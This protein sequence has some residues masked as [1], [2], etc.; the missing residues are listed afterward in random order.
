[1]KFKLDINLDDE[2][3]ASEFVAKYQ[4]FNTRREV[5][6]AMGLKGKGAHKLAGELHS[7]AFYKV[8]AIKYRKA[9]SIADALR[10]EAICDRI[11]SEGIQ[12]HCEC[13]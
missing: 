2:Q 1:M 4:F 12:P 13:W 9:G 10:Y 7:Y 6:K 5:A 11:Y 3:E 8:N